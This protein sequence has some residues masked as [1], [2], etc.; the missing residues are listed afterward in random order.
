MALA[1]PERH[2]LTTPFGKKLKRSTTFFLH[3]ITSSARY[4][5][6]LPTAY[7]LFYKT[8]RTEP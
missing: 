8:I 6:Q 2:G 4:I 3:Q 5:F 1:K 7:G